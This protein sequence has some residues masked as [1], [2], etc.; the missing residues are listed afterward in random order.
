MRI[1][2]SK[3]KNEITII[4][5]LAG[6]EE[7]VLYYR[8]PETDERQWYEHAKVV[9][10]GEDVEIQATTAAFNAGASIL[11]GIREGDFGRINDEGKAVPIASDPDSENYFEGWKEHVEKHAADHVIHLGLHVFERPTR[12]K[13][14][15]LK[16]PPKAPAG[17]GSGKT[18]V[19][20]S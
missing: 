6:S 16:D 14:A 2:S 13:K 9:R 17:G 20:S 1:L 4:D 18:R 15:P 8:I 3:A 7:H 5:D 19:K 11:T 10:D 12:V